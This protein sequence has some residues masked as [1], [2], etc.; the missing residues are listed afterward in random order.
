MSK[1]PLETVGHLQY[2]GISGVSF[3]AG[4][5]VQLSELNALHVNCLFNVRPTVQ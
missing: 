1:T 5:G 4:I 2:S 3:N